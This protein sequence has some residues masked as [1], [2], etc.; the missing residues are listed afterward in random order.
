MK[1]I[2]VPV[3]LAALIAAMLM[4]TSAVAAGRKVQLTNPDFTKGGVIPA[5]AKH[6]WT[7]GVTGARGWIFS[8]TFSTAKARQIAIT[9]V[10]KGSP[11][12]GILQ[13]GDVILGVGGKPF[14]YD[15]RTEFGKA[16]TVAETEA[17]G[18]KPSL[19]RWR[20]GKTEATRPKLKRLSRW[21]SSAPGSWCV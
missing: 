11:A 19:T 2:T 12:D 20:G 1:I 6:D 18:E 16:L 3:T 9:Q 5:D 4:D 15:P 21:M 14:S 13:K 10:A 17:A 7:L 8:E